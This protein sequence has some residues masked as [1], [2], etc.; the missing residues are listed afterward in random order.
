MHQVAAPGLYEVVRGVTPKVRCVHF[1]EQAVDARTV[2]HC[3]GDIRA[4]MH[5][6]ILDRVPEEVVQFV[7]HTVAHRVDAHH[8][9][10]AFAPAPE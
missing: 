4:R 5:V 9:L 10:Q 8:T 2:A 1:D 6:Q 3:G 7:R